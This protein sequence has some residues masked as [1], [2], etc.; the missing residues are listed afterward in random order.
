MTA[1]AAPRAFAQ[2]ILDADMAV[3]RA[4]AHLA[5]M[6]DHGTLADVTAA[7]VTTRAAHDALTAA[8]RPLEAALILTRSMDDNVALQVAH[9]ITVG[10]S[11]PYTRE[12][13]RDNTG[14]E[15]TP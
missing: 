4:E 13:I 12:G 7:A 15:P 5:A 14:W 2:Q 3:A 6:N 9:A 10:E 8:R 1:H 11:W